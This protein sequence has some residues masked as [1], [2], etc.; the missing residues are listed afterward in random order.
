MYCG[1][2]ARN[3]SLLAGDVVRGTRYKC[4]RKGIG[5]GRN[6]D[7]DPDYLGEYIPIDR[8]KIWCG[9]SDDFPDGY[10]RIGNL[11]QCL[12]KGIGVGKKQ[13]AQ[14]YID[15]IGRPTSSFPKKSSFLS[16]PIKNKFIILL[17][18]YLVIISIIFIL[19]YFIRPSYITYI[20]NGIIKISIK[21]FIIIYLP[22]CLSILLCFVWFY[23]E[24]SE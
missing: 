11:S 1:N 19:L 24:Q 20:D 23:M 10:D 7:I 13:K 22:I 17:L 15:L 6:Q 5:I 18:L 21:K 12:Q 3:P 9:N 16:K 2:N 14:E 8:R 4:L